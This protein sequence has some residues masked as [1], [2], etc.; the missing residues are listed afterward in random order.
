MRR[1]KWQSGA[2]AGSVSPFADAMEF[3][4]ISASAGCSG[5]ESG[6]KRPIAVDDVEGTVMPQRRHQC[7]VLPDDAGGAAQITDGRAEERVGARPLV[8]AQHVDEYLVLVRE[9]FDQ[10]QQRRDDLLA[11]A[12]VDAAGHDKSDSHARPL[13]HTTP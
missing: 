5:H 9:P 4:A 6:G 8:I 11:A 7:G 3:A 1:A 12:L 2:V 10:P 13:F